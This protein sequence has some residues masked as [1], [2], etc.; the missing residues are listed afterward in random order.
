MACTTRSARPYQR[1]GPSLTSSKLSTTKGRTTSAESALLASAYTN[2]FYGDERLIEYV[3]EMRE[4][5]YGDLPA[6]RPVGFFKRRITMAT[7]TLSHGCASAIRQPAPSTS[8]QT[9]LIQ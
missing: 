3:K 5:D 1:L 9:I 6:H 2:E 4:G 7:W 8:A